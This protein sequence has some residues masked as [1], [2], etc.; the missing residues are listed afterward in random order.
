MVVDLEDIG[1]HY[2]ETLLRWHQNVQD[3]RG[4]IADLGLDDRFQRLWDLYLCYCA[5]AFAE[6]HISDV[7]MVMAMP[8]WQAPITVRS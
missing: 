6:R 4:E 3:H 8:D 2:V 7:Q 5:G 1:R